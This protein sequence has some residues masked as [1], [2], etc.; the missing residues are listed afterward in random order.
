M[1][2]SKI[3]GIEREGARETDRKAGTQNRTYRHR[4]E[5]NAREQAREIEIGG[6][7]RRRRKKDADEDKE[8][9]KKPAMGSGQRG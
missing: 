6:R 4:D 1:T 5:K 8:M 3:E 2:G 7:G 9:E